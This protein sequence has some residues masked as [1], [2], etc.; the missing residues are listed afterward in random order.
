MPKGVYIR[1]EKHRKINSESHKGKKFTEQHKQNLSGKNN[2]RWMGNGACYEAKHIRI[3]KKLGNPRY[4]EKCKRTDKKRYD[5]ANKDHKYSEDIK[6]WMRLC[7]S[8]H[9]K[10]DIKF[11][12]KQN[13]RKAKNTLHQ[14][15]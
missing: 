8:C 2:G 15:H 3:I 9:T 11:N 14:Q 1:T 13:G 4:C 12:K 10:Y 5:W 6:D 7:R